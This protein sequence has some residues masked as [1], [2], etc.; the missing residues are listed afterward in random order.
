MKN[1]IQVTFIASLILSGI[2]GH[3]LVAKAQQSLSVVYPPQDHQ[4]TSEQIFLIGTASPEEA[5]LVNGESIKRSPAGHFAP[6]FPLELGENTFQLRHNNQD[7]EIT[8]TRVSNEPTIPTEVAFAE[9]SLTPAVNI[10]KLPGETICFS[11]VAPPEAQVSVNLPGVTIPL[12]AETES[13]TLPPNSGVLVGENT[14]NSSVSTGKYRGCHQF[15]RV[16]NFGKPNFE[17][18]LKEE[19]FTQQGEGEIKIAA[20]NSLEVV[21]VIEDGG[22]ARTGASTNYSRLTPLPKGTRARVTGK[23]GEWL[24]LDY[25]AWIK[26]EETQP[27][28]SNTPTDSLIRSVT[29]R[30]LEQETEIIFPLQAPVPVGIQQSDESIT[31]TLYNTTAQTDT[32]R[33]DDN[34]LIKRLDWQQVTPREIAY[35]FQLKTDRQWGYNLRYEGTTLIFT[36]RH[37][38]QVSIKSQL[39]LEGIKILLDPGHGGAEAGAKGSTGYPE[40]EINLVIS[41]LLETELTR[42][43]ATVYLTRETDIDLGLQER[44]DMINEIKPDLAFSIHYNALPDNGDAENTQ[45]ISTFWYHPQAHDLAISLQDYL[46]TT[47]DRPSY[48]VFWNN[49]AL[50]RPHIAPTILLELGFMINPWEFEWITDT[51]EQQKLVKAIAGGIVKW[52]QDEG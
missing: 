21:E 30:Q 31:L 37:P 5:V 23:E 43:G 10:I 34:P 47:L 22:I 25:G 11:A 14:P 40:K 8:V 46:V 51:N 7:L 38:P 45:G 26:A 17:V 41:Q 20:A 33:L 12:L 15:E 19:S 48:G 36:L 27:L 13:V 42:L 2:V 1:I 4:T 6:S 39:P 18:S 49:L 9:N 44:I 3:S 52:V 32:I 50:T 29:S 28:P 24:R 16:G 35:T